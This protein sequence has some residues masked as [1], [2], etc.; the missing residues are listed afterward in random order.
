ML[1]VRILRYIVSPDTSRACFHTFAGG[2]TD[3]DFTHDLWSK[4]RIKIQGIA[5]RVSGQ[6]RD[7]VTAILSNSFSWNPI[8]SASTL[9][10]YLDR[11]PAKK[12]TSGGVVYIMI[13]IMVNLIT[14]NLIILSIEKYAIF[15]IFRRSDRKSWQEIGLG[16]SQWIMTSQNDLL[17]ALSISCFSIWF[18]SESGQWSLCHH[19]LFQF[20]I[21][22][23]PLSVNWPTGLLWLL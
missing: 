5:G 14:N 12:L 19:W 18:C 9:V 6:G 2:A 17:M 22:F 15:S 3:L 8:T 7:L 11:F 16:R 13:Y 1:G 23:S 4:L 10:S 20:Y 21:S